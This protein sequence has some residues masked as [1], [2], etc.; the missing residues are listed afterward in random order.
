LR[1]EKNKNKKIKMENNLMCMHV[2]SSEG[3]IDIYLME[4][5][6]EFR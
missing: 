3:G 1:E 4:N 6:L 2:A 5:S